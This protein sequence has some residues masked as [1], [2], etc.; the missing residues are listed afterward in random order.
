[1]IAWPHLTSKEQVYG[2]F[3]P[4]QREPVGLGNVRILIDCAQ[5]V[6]TIVEGC[7]IGNPLKQ[8][9]LLQTQVA[10]IGPQFN[11]MQC[12]CPLRYLIVMIFWLA[13]LSD[14][15][16]LAC[17]PAQKQKI[18]CLFSNGTPVLQREVQ[19]QH[20]IQPT[21]IPNPP[22]SCQIQPTFKGIR[23]ELKGIQHSKVSYEDDEVIEHEKTHTTKQ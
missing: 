1:M 23:P 2:L 8:C 16:K 18:I 14:T 17:P 19:Y 3:P 20:Q 4:N 5:T 13:R 6:N 21:K 7:F 9:G 12:N 22:Q 15:T 11:A 10:V